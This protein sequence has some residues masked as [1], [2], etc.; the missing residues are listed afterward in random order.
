MHVVNYLDY[1][2]NFSWGTYTWKILYKQ[3]TK[4]LIGKVDKYKKEHIKDHIREKY[5]FS[6]FV[7]GVQVLKTK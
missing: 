5:N 3:M 2:N 1:F 7:Y 4:S 6:G